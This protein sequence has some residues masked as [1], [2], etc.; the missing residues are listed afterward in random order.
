MSS[1]SFRGVLLVICGFVLSLVTD[2]ASAQGPDAEPLPSWNDG[3]AKSSIVE[4]V[5]KVTTA[6]SPTFVPLG[7][8]I[9]VFDND[10]TLWCEQPMY[11]QLAFAI[12]RIKALAPQHP[13]WQTQ[14]PFAAVLKDDLKAVMVGGEAALLELVMASHAGM[15]TTEFDA[16]AREWIRTAR[17]PKLNRPYTECVYQPMLELLSFLR[18]HGFKTYIVSG[19][20]VEFIR[21]WAEQ[22]YG[23]PPEQVI[24]SSIQ[25]Q[26]VVRDDQPVL[27]RLP[28]IDF[29]DDKSGKPVGIQR[30]IGRRPLMAFGN[31]DGDFQML[32]WTTTGEGPRFGL[33]V[34][35]T[36]GLREYAYDRQ[37][38]IGRLDRGLTEAVS[39]K[40]TVIDMQTDWKTVF[41]ESK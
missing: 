2:T 17:H 14:A 28:K 22:V 15:T 12:D 5:A 4:F 31:S 41:P 13:E 21:P 24:G 33:L 38:S 40:W 26:Y 25:T 30:I 10:G 7:E 9:A 29:I 1:N 8:R 39:R 37:S 23:I 19:G 6:D 27:V 3:P 11:V 20:G 34:H 35:H 18:S 36:D 16:I 32:E